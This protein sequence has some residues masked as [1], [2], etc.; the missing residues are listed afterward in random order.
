MMK[1]TEKNKNSEK[2]IFTDI[3]LLIEQSRQN[4]ATTV[5]AKITILY[6]NIGG[7][8]NK[9]ILTNRGLSM[10]SR[11]SRTYHTI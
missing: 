6:W 8:I 3:A 9:E 2:G 11:L 7:R 5:N 4:V 10:V 1:K